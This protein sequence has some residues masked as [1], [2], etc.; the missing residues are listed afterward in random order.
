MVGKTVTHY[1]VVEELGG[2]GM[3]VVYRAED[4]YLGRYV[5]LKFLPP[6]FSQDKQALDRFAREARAAAAL[7][8]PNICTIHEIGE[9]EGQRFIAMELLE[10]ET[11]KHRVESG[12]IKTDELLDLAIQIADALDA[13]HTRGI[14]HRD[15]KPANIFVTRRGHA[16]VLDFGLAKLVARRGEDQQM[17]A[18]N[19]DLTSPGTSI[20]TVAYM[21]PEQARGEE[22]DAR[23]DLFSLGTVL[24][25]MA[26]GKH[27]F[28][29]NTSAMTFDAILHRPAVA[30]ARLNA[31]LPG[32]LERIISKA[33]E[34]D[35][36]GRYQTAADL[37]G[38]LKRLKQATDS[39]RIT[40][41]GGRQEEKAGKSLAVL[42]FENLSQSAEDEYFRDGMTEDII[43]EL[44]G[45][46]GLEV[47][48]RATVLAYRNK[49]VTP[50]EVGEQLNA[51]YVVSGSLR[52]AGNRLRITTQL[53]E[54]RT[55]RSVWGERFDREMKD[56]FEVQD[57]IAR[58]ITEALRIT[59]SPQEEAKIA[60]KP[61]EDLQAYDFYLRGRNY[62]RR[63][64]LDFA[65]QMFEQAI[66]L[67]PKFALAHAGVASVCGLIYELR[68]KHP[69]W[70][71][72]GLE[73]CDLAMAA[74]PG[75]AE[76]LAARARVFY[77][78]QKFE[79]A[80]AYA[81]LAVE[82]KP[83]CEGAYNVLGRAYFA[84]DRFQEAAAIVDKALEA[85][86]DDYNVYIPY[87]A[88]LMRLGNKE[89][90]LKV[91][92]LQTTALE[93]QLEVVPDDVRARVLLATNLA[94]AGRKEEAV[95]HLQTAIVLR[96][97]DGNTLYNAACVYGVLEE[98]APAMDMVR[99]ALDAGYANLEWMRRDG[100]LQCLHGDPDFE[101]LTQPA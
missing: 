68:E 31:S 71:E 96:P 28:A 27:A 46:K 62:A 82:K 72:R 24:Y 53:V 5:A 59:L 84:S 54:T 21:S 92:E 16:K 61:T 19:A 49:Q 99:R 60:R 26:T 95:R 50:T 30:P 1:Q 91:R 18:S 83:D 64:N 15:I 89:K 13:A 51:A 98:K 40:P 25:E 10:G 75:R 6:A 88:S 97:D 74:D 87:S 77:G 33:L 35:R 17:T 44:L 55:G 20:G 69:R 34:K 39:G 100:D 66:R 101:R 2:G 90:A 48:P 8:H 57:E 70:I 14:V 47:F 12:S 85:S 94:A 58:R 52:R 4:T 7:N 73:A 78:Q 42:Y 81:R 11:L 45:I 32:E 65:L 3:G 22:L 76:V 43:T 93:R 29:G 37:R 38:D 86:G 67:D 80:A 41:Q 9:H 36:T 56:V 23:S 63:E 79:E